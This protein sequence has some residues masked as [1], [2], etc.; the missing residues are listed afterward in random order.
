MSDISQ[1]KSEHLDLCATDQVAFQDKT[2]LLEQVGLVHDALPELAVADVGLHTTLVGHEL[3]APVVIAAMTGGTERAHAVNRDLASV[4]E[5]LG[6]GFGFGSMRPLLE[7]GI[8]AGYQVR[9]VAPGALILGNLGIV[10]ARAASTA[11]IARM[12]E[13]TGCSALCVHLNP[14]MEVIQ[15]G[16]DDDFRGGLQVLERLVQQLPVPVI[17]KETGCGLSRSV[18]RRLRDVGIEAVD[19]SGAGGTSWV[20][21]ETL[22]ARARTRRLGELF[23]DWGIPTAA[24]VAQLSGLGLQIVATGGVAD[25]LDVARAMALGAT[26]GGMAR[27]FLMAW[28]EGGREGVRIAADEVVEEL[29]IACLLTG[30]ASPRQLAERPVVLGPQLRAWLPPDSPLALRTTGG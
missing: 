25:G 13:Q 26:A 12:V 20:G 27:R 22:R 10:Q 30:C 16:G 11:Q 6:I 21:V 17:A 8:E 7:A 14:A 24:S 15:P 19:V 18:G 9:D 3:S 23:W 2:T 5:E 4:A 29:R 1:R 28:N